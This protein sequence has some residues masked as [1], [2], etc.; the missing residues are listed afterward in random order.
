LKQI[1]NEL[2]KL[3]SNKKS[4]NLYEKLPERV[5]QDFFLNVAKEHELRRLK[6]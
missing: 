4:E 2:L 1:K 3:K 5:K 6:K